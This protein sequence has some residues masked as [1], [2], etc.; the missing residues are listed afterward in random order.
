[1][2]SLAIIRS[3]TPVVAYHAAQW[4]GVRLGH[5]RALAGEVLSAPVPITKSTYQS[6]A[7]APQ[8]ST[9]L[10]EGAV[11]IVQT[12]ET[13]ASSQPV[14][15][16]RCD[17][18][19][20]WRVSRSH[21]VR[22]CS[23]ALLQEMTPRTQIEIVE[24]LPTKLKSLIRQIGL[25]LLA[26]ALTSEPLGRLYAES[27]AQTLALH[28]VRHYSVSSRATECFGTGYRAT[29]CAGRRSLSTSIWSRI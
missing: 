22:R 27:L 12:R 24:L 2:G 15:P 9:P 28:L 20:K 26:E 21:S 23:R 16:S 5:W 3:Q 6:P 7:T 17:G 8:E 29:T 1:M 13:S 25:A 14:S 11:Q 18:A 10:P 4:N 19:K